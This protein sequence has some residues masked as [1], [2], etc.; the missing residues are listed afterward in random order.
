MKGP[1]RILFLYLPTGGGHISAAR[2]L[3]AEIESR[4]DPGGVELFLLDGLKPKSRFQRILVEKGYQF[5]TV[6][7]PFLWPVIFQI[8][9]L[10]TILMWHTLSMCAYSVPHIRRFIREKRITRVV[11]LHFL[12]TRPLHLALK[13]SDSIDIP[14]CTVVLD[15]FTA[16][17][18]WFYKQFMPLVVFSERV[19]KNAQHYLRR[20]AVSERLLP[21]AAPAIT[22]YPPILNPKFGKALPQEDVRMLKISY[23]FNPDRR[24]VLISGG[25]EG[26]P[27]GERYLEAIRGLGLDVDLAVVCGKNT[28]LKSQC[29][30]IASRHRKDAQTTKVYGFVDFM[31]E[32]VNMADIIVT[33]AGPATIFEC[34][35]MEKPLILTQ[36]FYGQE[37]G[38]VDFVV[39]KGLG[40]FLPHPRDMAAK[41][42]ELLERP[43][44]FEEIRQRI[45]DRK[46]MNGSA[47]IADMILSLPSPSEDG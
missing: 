31:Y 23:G 38:N 18:L 34:L 30:E 8:S 43:Q 24:L 32:L 33:K 14:A 13:R 46:L 10:R 19:R 37:Q 44:T 20:Y 27:K 9:R 5:T 2:A 22:V 28:R 39:N 1:E 40:W 3:A 6:K 4:F 16:H 11:N 17:P 36:R 47:Q 12:L 35:L 21:K 45:R 26:L 15:P 41:I 42:Q 25:G 7:V 29:K